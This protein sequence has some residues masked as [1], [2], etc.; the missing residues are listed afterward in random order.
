MCSSDLNLSQ[1]L[2]LANTFG[3]SLVNGARTGDW[4]GTFMQLM[5]GTVP[6]ADMVINRLPSVQARDAVND[7]TR[8]ARV[9]AGPL[10]LSEKSGSGGGAQPTRFSNLVKQ[11]EAAMANGDRAEA[12]ALLASAA[13]EKKKQGGKDPWGAVR[14][15]IQSRDV[16]TRTFGRKLTD[17]ERQGLMSRMSDKQRAV[18][19]QAAENLNNL[20]ELVPASGSRG[21][22]ESATKSSKPQTPID[23]IN[24]R[25]SKINK[26]TQPKS[27]RA[28][29]KKLKSLRPKKISKIKI[30]G[31]KVASG[32]RLLR[33]KA[34]GRAASALLPAV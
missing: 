1:P 18:Y 8:V 9:A 29:N 21:E 16:D 24:R 13:E 23:R 28:I 26:M 5:R 10:E 15:A 11:A 3:Q 22:L 12:Q 4:T 17:D 27:L 34:P 19:T 6:G 7:A 25:F 31:P 33:P 32:S 30:S 20:K 14:S 2:Q